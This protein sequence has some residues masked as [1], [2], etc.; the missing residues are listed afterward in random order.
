MTIKTDKDA[1]AIISGKLGQRSLVL[2][3]LMGAGKSAIGRKVATR[4]NMPFVD[5]DA[6]IEKAAKQTV[7]DIFANYGEEE[8][9]RL[10]ERVIA[11]LLTEGPQVLATGGG[12]YMNADT[13]AA[14][15]AGG[16]SLWLSA[17]IDLLMA[18]VSKKATRPLLQKPNPRRIMQELIDARYPIYA[19]ADMTVQSRDVTKDEMATLVINAIAAH[20]SAQP[21]AESH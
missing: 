17:D 21:S 5:A 9:R 8:F 12:A 11:R 4:L 1:V 14:I 10:E 7:A 18:R 19:Q 15:G 16:V 3:G 6:E 20:L 2:V 13:R